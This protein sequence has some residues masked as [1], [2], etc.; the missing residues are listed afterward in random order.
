MQYSISNYR[1]GW[2]QKTQELYD[3]IW[4][5]SGYT[6]ASCTLTSILAVSSDENEIVDYH[7]FDRS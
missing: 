7:V 3:G 2:C 1:E 5:L 4:Y 6:K